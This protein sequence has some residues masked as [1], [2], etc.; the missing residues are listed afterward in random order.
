MCNEELSEDYPKYNCYDA[1]EYCLF[2][3]PNS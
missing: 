1:G 2:L 3:I